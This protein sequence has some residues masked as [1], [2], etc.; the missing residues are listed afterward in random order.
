MTRMV[1][2]VKLGKEAVGLDFPPL[3]GEIG[4]RIFSCISKEIWQAWLKQQT[5]LINENRLNMIDPH[6]RQYLLK[7]AKKFLFSEDSDIVSG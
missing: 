6:A 1:Y 7:Q 3:P 5:M 4:K 2:C